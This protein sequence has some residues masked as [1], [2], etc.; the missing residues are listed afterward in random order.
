MRTDTNVMGSSW[1]GLL[2]PLSYTGTQFVSYDLPAPDDQQSISMEWQPTGE[3]VIEHSNIPFQ[4][5]P[6]YTLDNGYTSGLP[7][8]HLS[9]VTGPP[10]S[11]HVLFIDDLGVRCEG[12][13]PSAG[14]IQN[15]SLGHEEAVVLPGSGIWE[16]YREQRTASSSG[17]SVDPPPVNDP[18]GYAHEVA[19]SS[20]SSLTLEQVQYSAKSG[21]RGCLK[22]ERR[23]HA[24]MMRKKHACWN[25]IILKYPVS[26]VIERLR[27][28]LTNSS[29]T[30]AISVGNVVGCVRQLCFTRHRLTVIGLTS[31]L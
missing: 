27:I 25:C 22:P 20:H 4:S 24:A 2:A 16:N 29:V 21:R 14:V 15:T 8:S 19:P 26:V 6:D 10:Q 13:A 7:W 3:D 9:A 17:D 1:P 30:E 31:L 12:P 11:D 28:L 23:E 18:I 5:G